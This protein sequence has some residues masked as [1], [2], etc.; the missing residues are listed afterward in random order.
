MKELI[1]F[2]NI[3]DEEILRRDF[4]KKYY[5]NGTWS[6]NV[7][8]LRNPPPE[9]Y[10]SLS[11]TKISPDA[12]SSAIRIYKV[13]RLKNLVGYALL[14]AKSIREIESPLDKQLLTTD[15]ED[16]AHAGLFTW[17]K[18][19]VLLEG[20]VDDPDILRL[21]KDLLALAM[22][23]YNEYPVGSFDAVINAK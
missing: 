22:Q 16:N 21:R 17:T 6:F 8:Q 9:N 5:D 7:F 1:T 3:K 15:S 12:V 10:I 20:G 4:F 13:G 14:K 2:D 23:N 19:G 18:D 11:R